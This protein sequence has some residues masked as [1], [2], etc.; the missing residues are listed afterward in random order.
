MFSSICTLLLLAL[1]AIYSVQGFNQPSL[2]EKGI[3][4]VGAILKRK[5]L[6]RMVSSGFLHGD[7]MHLIFNAFTFYSFGS[8]LEVGKGGFFMLIV[9]FLSLIG[10]NALSLL[11]HRK[12]SSYRALGASGAVSG[13]MF[14]V[15][16]L[17]PGLSVNMFFIPID[18][19]G[20]V[21]ALFFTV[22]SIVGMRHSFDNIGHD[23]HLGGAVVGILT[24]LAFYPYVLFQNP[25]IIGL[26][27]VPTLLLLLF[28]KQLDRLG[29]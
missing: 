6:L 1:I 2:L 14:S 24:T 8:L 22:Y 4:N 10:G 13:V 16:I 27:L 29:M 5:E 12:D 18:V 26:V 19:P 7:W 25:L 15:I 3:F 9:F 21:Y 11:L 28:Y 17:V 23:A 20:W